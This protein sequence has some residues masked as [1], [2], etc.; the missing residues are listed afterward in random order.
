MK[1]PS[2][3]GGWLLA[4]LLLACMGS[5]VLGITDEEAGAFLGWGLV[6]AGGLAAQVGVVAKGVEVGLQVSRRP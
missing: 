6:V 1:V 4:G 3:P 5:V 2:S